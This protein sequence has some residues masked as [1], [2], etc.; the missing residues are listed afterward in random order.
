[1]TLNP[2]PEGFGLGALN[3]AEEDDVDVYD[4]GLPQESRR[5]A[6]EA[7][8][9]EYETVVLGNRGPAVP[10]KVCRKLILALTLTEGI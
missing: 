3:D 9:E 7:V 2:R 5:M 10:S 8:D 6:F 4:N 1:M